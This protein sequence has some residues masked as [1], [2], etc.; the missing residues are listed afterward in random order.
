MSE[1]QKIEIAKKVVKIR[2]FEQALD[3]FFEKGII[4]G[5]YHRSIGQEATAVGLISNNI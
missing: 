1:L 3:G 5:T 2:C 4:S